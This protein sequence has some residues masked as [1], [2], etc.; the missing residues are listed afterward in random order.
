MARSSSLSSFFFSKNAAKDP[1]T[2]DLRLLD[3]FIPAIEDL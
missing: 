1:K 2:L 3:S